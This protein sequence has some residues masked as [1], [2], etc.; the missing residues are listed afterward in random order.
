MTIVG[1]RPEFI[2]VAPLTRLIR[3]VNTEILVNTGQHYDDNMARVFFDELGLPEPEINLGVGSGSHAKQTAE[4]M[5]AMETVMLDEKP[6]YVIVYGDTNST[7]AAAM[8]A[9]KLHIPLAHIESGL[10]SFDRKMPEEVNRIVTDH[11]SQLLFAPTQRA[12]DNLA[13]EGITAGVHRT[14]DV[15]VDILAHFSDPAK[16]RI[17]SLR[18]K[19]GF[20]PDENFALTTIHRPANTDDETRLTQIINTLN[21]LD[22]AILLP[23]H[24]RLKKMLDAYNLQIGDN[25]HLVDPLGFLDMM[26]MLHASEIVITDSGGL[27]KEAY[28]LHRQTVT[29]RDST[30]WVETVDAG[31]NRLCEPDALA[32]AVDVARNTELSEHPD[33]YGNPGVCEH[34][35]QTMIEHLPAL[36]V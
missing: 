6:D 10:R 36:S 33:Y 29:V 12:V 28:M 5:I 31:W 18:E 17:P 23:A 1:T 13:D 22:I 4:I 7:V 30:E 14:G 26:A 15:R 9:A 35:L 3:Q 25:I 21:D 19:F 16:Q 32:A 34:I 2:Q 20:S 8:V 11:L 27:Q 24:P